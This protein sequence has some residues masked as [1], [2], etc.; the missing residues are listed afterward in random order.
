MYRLYELQWPSWISALWKR[1]IRNKQKPVLIGQTQQSMITTT[2]TITITVGL[3][4]VYIFIPS[5]SSRDV[6]R[7]VWQ[8]LL[9]ATTM[10]LTLNWLLICF[11]LLPIVK[12][13]FVITMFCFSFLCS[14]YTTVVN[15]DEWSFAPKSH[16]FWSCNSIEDKNA[17]WTMAMGV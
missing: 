5:Y 7:N 10:F 14:L 13:I 15:G 4:A 3:I 6:L 11:A 17:R 8:M 16:N 12:A 2:T 9:L 1:S